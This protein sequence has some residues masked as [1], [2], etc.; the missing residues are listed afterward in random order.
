[1]EDHEE[2][3]KELFS[4]ELSGEYGSLIIHSIESGTPRVIY[5]NV[6]N[7]GLIDNLPKECVVEVPCHV[8]K[9]GVQP[10][11]I[12]PIPSQLAALMMTNINLKEH[13][14]KERL[15][16][17]RS[18]RLALDGTAPKQR[19]CFLATAWRVLPILL[20]AKSQAS[21]Y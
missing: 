10:I 19:D 2:L 1:M 21:P 15:I 4:L 8:D 7:Y 14:L 20:Q 17:R 3:L 12:G 13:V 6:P 18:F 9:N 16:M 11:Q 5:G